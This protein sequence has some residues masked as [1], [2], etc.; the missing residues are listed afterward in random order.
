VGTGGRS[1]STVAQ[2]SW[3]ATELLQTSKAQARLEQRQ[4]PT[5]NGSINP[6]QLCACIQ[7]ATTFAQLQAV[8]NTF[9]G[10]AAFGPQQA[11]LVLSRLHLVRSRPT[12]SHLLLVELLAELL[13]PGCCMH[14]HQGS[15]EAAGVMQQ[16]QQQSVPQ[17]GLHQCQHQLSCGQ[18]A[19]V[20]WAFSKAGYQPAPQLLQLLLQQFWVDFGQQQQRGGSTMPQGQA[21]QTASTSN[22]SSA[23]SNAEPNQHQQWPPTA[24][25]EALATLVAGLA[26]LGCR[27][28]S[29]WQRLRAAVQVAL[30]DSVL[31][32]HSLQQ[33]TWGFAAVQQGDAA[34]VD[35]LAAT[36]HGRLAELATPEDLVQSVW[37]LHL[38]G[39]TDG[40]LFEAAAHVML[41]HLQA[42]GSSAS[43]SKPAPAAA[44][45]ADGASSST[46]SQQ[47]VLLPQ[48]PPRSAG[49]CSS[50]SAH[51]RVVQ[52]QKDHA[53]LVVNSR[54]AARQDQLQSLATVSN[55][56]RLLSA[57]AG[58]TAA[59]CSAAATQAFN[60]LHKY[61]PLLCMLALYR[62]YYR[63][64]HSM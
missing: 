11:A 29:C 56:Q 34:T 40:S 27:D 41:Q 36:L 43:S 7:A 58:Q 33:L 49:S 18:A 55:P 54:Q 17:A 44:A 16:Q 3:S 37:S 47:P 4:Q 28:A 26:G 46:R 30:S 20:C 51:P 39:C 14:H 6:Q 52:H 61:D 53:Q 12:D 48:L 35:V 9:M 59:L 10:H 62:D 64:A 15:P 8:C 45:R 21:G 24:A 31:P 32:V 60:V 2:Q 19:A 22:S 25:D 1:A 42:P 13:P 63:P 23:T 50:A 57:A 38:M 5:R